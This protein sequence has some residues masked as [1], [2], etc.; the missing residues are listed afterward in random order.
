MAKLSAI[1]LERNLSVDCKKQAIRIDW[2]NDRHQRIVIDSDSPDAVA[3]ALKEAGF[4]V[5]AE[6]VHGNI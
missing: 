5:N 1:W 4:M 3:H 2:D 6:F